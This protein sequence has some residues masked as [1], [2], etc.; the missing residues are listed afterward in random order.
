[1]VAYLNLILRLAIWFLLTANF[2]LANIIIGVSIALL[3]P[4]LPKVSGTLKDWL[5]VLWEIIV[6]IPQAYIEAFEIIFR[7][8]K[9]EEVTLEQ[10]KPRRTPGLIFLDIF[11]ITFTPKTIVLKYHEAGWYEVHWVRRRKKV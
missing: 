8:H 7:P 3:L 1:M 2:S 9:Y 6:A 5:R 10:V 11:L 4:G